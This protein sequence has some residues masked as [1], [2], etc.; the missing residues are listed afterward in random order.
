MNPPAIAPALLHSP[1]RTHATVS[2]WRRCL[3]L[4]GGHSY[5]TTA[6]QLEDS[7]LYRVR[8]CNRCHHRRAEIVRD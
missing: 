4:V 7:V 6:T 3:C 5:V 8:V 2:R 1:A